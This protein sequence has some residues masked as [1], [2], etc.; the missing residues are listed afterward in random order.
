MEGGAG[1]GKPLRM[2]TPNRQVSSEDGGEPGALMICLELP[3]S[4]RENCQ[5]EKNDAVLSSRDKKETCL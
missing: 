4:Q 1:V 3:D 5:L 2:S